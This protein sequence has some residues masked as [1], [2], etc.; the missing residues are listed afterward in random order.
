MIRKC[1][2]FIENVNIKLSPIAELIRNTERDFPSFEVSLID[3]EYFM[4]S[5]LVVNESFEKMIIEKG[6]IYFGFSPSFNNTGR[7]FWFIK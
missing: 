5:Q 2:R 1:N 3:N 7:S 4:K 6:I